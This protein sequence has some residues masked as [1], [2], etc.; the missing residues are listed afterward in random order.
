[1]GRCEWGYQLGRDPL[2]DPLTTL[3]G[4]LELTTAPTAEPP[5]QGDDLVWHEEVPARRIVWLGHGPHRVWMAAWQLRSRGH[6]LL[7]MQCS[8][9]RRR[10]LRRPCSTER[11]DGRCTSCSTKRWDCKTTGGCCWCRW[12]ELDQGP[13]WPGKG[14]AGECVSGAARWG[15]DKAEGRVGWGWRVSQQHSSVAWPHPAAF[16]GLSTLPTLVPI[17]AAVLGILP[18]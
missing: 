6:S 18:V 11:T 13:P 1:M 7:V 17:S 14:C 10:F 15:R 9:G 2:T 5:V 4:H 8:A 3:R 12:G 16:P